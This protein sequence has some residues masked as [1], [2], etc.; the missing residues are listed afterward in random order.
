MRHLKAL[1]F[2]WIILGVYNLFSQNVYAAAAAAAARDDV[3]VGAGTSIAAGSFEEAIEFCYTL[4]RDNITWIEGLQEYWNQDANKE[5][6]KVELRKKV[7]CIEEKHSEAIEIMI[8]GYVFEKAQWVEGLTEIER[9]KKT[10]DLVAFLNLIIAKKNIQKKEFYTILHGAAHSECKRYVAHLFPG[11]EEN[12]KAQWESLEAVFDKLFPFAS[13]E[14]QADYTNLAFGFIGAGGKIN[15]RWQFDDEGV[16]EAAESDGSCFKLVASTGYTARFPF[17]EKVKLVPLV[18]FAKDYKIMIS[19]LQVKFPVSGLEVTFL[20]LMPDQA[21]NYAE[22]YA[23]AKRAYE[24]LQAMKARR[25]AKTGGGSAVATMHAPDDRS[26]E[27]LLAE[28][29]EPAAAAKKKKG[30]P[31]TKVAVTASAGVEDAGGGAG[32]DARVDA[33]APFKLSPELI[34]KTLELAAM[35]GREGAIPMPERAYAPRLVGTFLDATQKSMLANLLKING[36]GRYGEIKA[37]NTYGWDDLVSM[38]RGLGFSKTSNNRFVYDPVRQIGLHYLHYDDRRLN[39]DLL[40]IM[41]RQLENIGF[42]R[43]YLQGLLEA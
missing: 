25:T 27:D 38:L 35:Q 40:G 9:L 18:F 12:T 19:N 21:V 20:T 26:I 28:M 24:K 15:P 33:T 42:T 13:A 4:A 29:G 34:A 43:D 5:K 41:F 3:V 14:Y 8:T 37:I 17:S 11:N 31:H 16:E 2:L 23:N 6:V 32:G 1:T 7:D 39:G 10:N 22:A 30:K 36:D